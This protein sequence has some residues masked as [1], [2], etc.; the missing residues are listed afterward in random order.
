MEYKNPTLC[1]KIKGDNTENLNA[2]ISRK[3]YCEKLSRELIM[4]CKKSTA[5]K[6]VKK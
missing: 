3:N 4:G 6:P 1:F 5:K 2:M